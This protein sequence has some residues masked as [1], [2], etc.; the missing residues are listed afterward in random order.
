MARRSAAG[1]QDEAPAGAN[2][3]GSTRAGKLEGSAWRADRGFWV[4]SMVR[5]RRKGSMG[6]RTRI[7]RMTGS[8]HLAACALET[9]LEKA[10]HR[11]PCW[12]DVQF[13]DREDLRQLLQRLPLHHL[14]VEACLEHMAAS[15][16]VAYGD[17]LVITLPT[18][19]SWDEEHRSYLVVVC[20]P[21][22]LVT[23]HARPVPSLEHVMEQYADGMRFHAASTSA[24]LYQILD[25]IIDE[26]VGFAQQARE[27]IE[28][29]DA[30]LEV[31][32]DEAI[33]R[34]V[35]LKRQLSRLEAAF[36]DQL[37]CVGALQT[38]ESAA[39]RIGGLRDYF[40]DA[41]SHLEH[42]LRSIQRQQSQLNAVQQGYHLKLQDKTNDQLRVLTIISTVFLPLT[43]IAG[44]YGMNFDYM[45]E[46]HWRYGY[47]GT[48]AAMVLVSAGMLLTFWRAGWFR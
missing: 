1:P 34:A 31:D 22:L 27:E 15:R 5:Q 29:L 33:A 25:H 32:D 14:A 11:E 4:R 10:N 48:L 8:R 12:V 7:Y 3:D 17:S 16:L 47:F 38:I 35:P 24:V 9:A 36:E 46:L 45:P 30:L 20:L 39:F 6:L 13:D 19:T 26:D 18:H 28:Q 44:I 21:G 23:V 42:A 41:V 43:L 40:R 37:Y 2:Q